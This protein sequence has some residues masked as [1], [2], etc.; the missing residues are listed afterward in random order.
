M[1]RRDLMKN[2]SIAWTRTIAF[3]ILGFCLATCTKNLTPIPKE[4]YSTKII[5]SWQGTVGD[6]KEIMSINKDGTFVCKV[7]STGF[8]ANTLSQSLPGSISGTWKITGEMITLKITGAKNEQV[9]NR[10]ASSIIMGFKEDELI[11]K[12]DH[13]G[14]STFQR[15]HIHWYNS[16]KVR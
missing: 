14:T 4:Q 10:I 3:I 5:G 13:A 9:E 2:N 11:L 7:H 16:S 8:I 6:S 1:K 15:V 12:S